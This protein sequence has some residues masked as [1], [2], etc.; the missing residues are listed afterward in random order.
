MR[1]GSIRAT[2]GRLA[3]PVWLVLLAAACAHHDTPLRL[4]FTE[5][6]TATRETPTPALPLPADEIGRLL[7]AAPF[8]LVR[9]ERAP[10]GVMGVGHARIRFP[11]RD[12]ELD[13]KW[14]TA[15]SGDAD[16]WDNSPRKEI[17]AYAIQQWFLD[18]P[19]WVVPPTAIRCIALDRFRRLTP[20]AEA[21]IEGTRCVLGLLAAWLEN[22]EPPTVLYDAE[23]FTHDRRYAGHMA[24]LNLLTYLID[25]R[26]G[27]GGNFLVSKDADDGRVWAVDNGIAFGNWVWNYFVTNWNVIRVPALRRDAVERLRHVTPEQ[28]RSLLVLDELRA[29]A[30]GV[31]R[32]VEG[33]A[34]RHVDRGT[35]IAPGWIQFGLTADE[36]AAVDARRRELLERVDHGE[37]PLF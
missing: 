35:R 8:D 21:T 20:S 25:H 30:D 26:D 32:P 6:P 28:V 36:A 29:D 22:V 3:L 1:C 33:S 27:R 7:A 17:A 13:V 9:V 10:G 4:A 12:V 24:D 14:K 16:G 18:V 34:P 5:A 23:R 15:P 11:E 31:L 37:I 2:S 19:D